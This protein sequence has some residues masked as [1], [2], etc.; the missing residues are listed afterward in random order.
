MELKWNQKAYGPRDWKRGE[1]REAL[2]QQALED[3]GFSVSVVGRGARSTEYVRPDDATPM[4]YPDLMIDDLLINGKPVLIEVTGSDRRDLPYKDLLHVNI[5]KWKCAW[6]YRDRHHTFVV[7]MY[8][9]E[10]WYVVALDK[11]FRKNAQ[12]NRVKVNAR[13]R[14]KNGV[15][16]VERMYEFSNTMPG[17]YSWPNFVHALKAQKGDA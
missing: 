9:L 2:V 13:Q 6:D 16:W 5:T 3:A 15:E 7:H 11:K 1:Q 12:S 14:R 4:A 17:V 10:D 8:G